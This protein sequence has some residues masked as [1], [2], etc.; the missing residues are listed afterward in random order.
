MLIEKILA[1]FPNLNR[2][3]VE[4]Y[5]MELVN[6]VDDRKAFKGTV[7]DLMISMR[8]FANQQNDFYEAEKKKAQEK[9][10]KRVNEKKNMIPGMKRTNMG[11]E[12]D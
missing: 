10:L 2:T 12:P 6:N 11:D 7:R 8:S 4:A 1:S 3:Q 5:V 9:A